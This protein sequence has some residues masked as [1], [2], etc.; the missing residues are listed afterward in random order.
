MHADAESDEPHA[1]ECRARVIDA[2]RL[3]ASVSAQLRYQREVPFAD[4]SAELFCQWFDDCFWPDDPRLQALFNAD[5]WSA[6]LAFHR[7][8]DEV[9]APLPSP[10]PR[11]EQLVELPEWQSVVSAAADTLKV[12]G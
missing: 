4:V 10:L 8:F 2:L 7:V 12:F 5:E 9:S 11:V 6:L 1:I 3:L